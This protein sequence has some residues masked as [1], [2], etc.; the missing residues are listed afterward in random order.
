[1][2]EIIEHYTALT[3]RMPLP[4]KWSLGYQQSR[5]SYYPESRVMWIAKTFRDKQIPL[6]GIVLDADYLKDYEPF[7]IDETRFPDM[8][9][10]AATLA[11]MRI[12]LTASVNPG[13]RID[14]TYAAYRDGLAKDVL[15][16]F[17]DGEPYVADIYPNTN[18]FPDFTSAKARLWWRDWMKVYAD[19]GIHGLWN[20]M[21]E[22]AIDGQ[23]MPENV[24]F[25]MD[26]RGGSPAE[27]HNVYGMLMARASFESAQTYGGNRRPFVLSRAGF[28]G[29]QRYAAVWSGDNQAK[30]EHILLGA[31]LSNQMGLA[32]V[33]FVGPDVGGFIGDG[34]KALF[35]RWIEVGAFSPYLRNHR[36]SLAAANEPWAY[37][38]QAETIAK[39]WIG[40]RYRLMPY[41]Y[42]TFRHASMT[43]VPVQRCLCIAAPF[44]APVY[45][46]EHQSEFMLGDAL[47]VDPLTSRDKA[48]TTYLPAG[49][50]YDLFS[51]ARI[52]GGAEMRGEYPL[53]RIPVFVRAGA[54][55]PLQSAVQSTRDAT[56]GTLT[57]HVYY[58]SEP[59]RFAW[60]E[61]DG[62]TLDYRRGAFYLR[63]IAFDPA[64]RRIA[65]GPHSGSA[66]SQFRRIALVLHGFDAATAFQLDGRP[67]EAREETVRLLDP[68]ADLEPLYFDHAQFREL[69]AH[70]SMRAQKVL[71]FDN[72]AASV[73]SWR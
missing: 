10:L 7:R 70:E 51:D 11:S 29:I 61:D 24:V 41:L 43:G 72:A 40:F 65:F 60:Y 50:W 53:W 26:G 25:D 42:S 6:D 1:M 15:L 8:R 66:A 5:S 56:D 45:S 64:G 14:D 23:A 28:A 73:V 22:P 68:L 59:S 2:A 69:R 54:I 4:P 67:V 21:N 16:R 52:A 34:N 46:P 27:A 57:V 35:E 71:R 44:A 49:E 32:G 39:T 63:E 58:G 48:A 13:I 37:G 31:L 36:E 47:L 17:R 12:E 18:R 30:D 55:V 20:D 9:R 38:E 19:A 62:T 3:G 33:P